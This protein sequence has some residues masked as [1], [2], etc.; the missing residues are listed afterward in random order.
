MSNIPVPFKNFSQNTKMPLPNSNSV[1]TNFNIMPTLIS[2]RVFNGKYLFTFNNMAYN[3]NG[4]YNTSQRFDQNI[5]KKKLLAFIKES[6][7]KYIILKS[8]DTNKSTFEFDIEKWL[9]DAFVHT[10]GVLH[11]TKFDKR[12][13]LKVMPPFMVRAYGAR[14]EFTKYVA[15]YFKDYCKRHPQLRKTV[16]SIVTDKVEK[17]L[18]INHLNMFDY[19]YDFMSNN[20]IVRLKSVYV[21]SI[22][23]LAMEISNNDKSKVNFNTSVKQNLRMFSLR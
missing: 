23:A 15:T 22:I 13:R 17:T 19:E 2:S 9:D 7:R 1:S 4:L 12:Y 20:I 14:I 10:S 3:I 6:D 11:L 16:F 21:M 8:F 5:L 18:K